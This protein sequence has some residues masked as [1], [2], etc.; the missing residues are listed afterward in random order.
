MIPPMPHTRTPAE[1][2]LHYLEQDQPPSVV[3]FVD[4]EEIMTC[5]DMNEGRHFAHESETKF[6]DWKEICLMRYVPS[7]GFYV[8]S[9]MRSRG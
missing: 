8:R 7:Y 9:D 3:L 4:G 2:L 1:V 5:N 6:P